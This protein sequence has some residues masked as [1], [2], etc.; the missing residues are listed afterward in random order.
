MAY[1]HQQQRIAAGEAVNLVQRNRIGQPEVTQVRLGLGFRQLRQGLAADRVAVLAPVEVDPVQLVA[2]EDHEP[3]AVG[4]PGT[5][6]RQ[7][8]SSSPSISS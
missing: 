5:R 7:T 8:Q 6:V 2:A 1:Q 3:R 4:R